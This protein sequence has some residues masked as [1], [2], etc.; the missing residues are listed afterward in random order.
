MSG[1]THVGFGCRVAICSSVR[2]DVNGSHS[3]GVD[4]R[5]G[6]NVRSASSHIESP[7][8]RS[9]LKLHAY[10]Q[11]MRARS[12][13]L[14]TVAILACSLVTMSQASAVPF[15]ASANALSGGV[16]SQETQTIPTARPIGDIRQLLLDVEANAKHTEAAQRDY[17]Y[18]VRTE[19]Q[20]LDGHEQV[21]KITVTE[22]ESLT[23]Q[24]VRVNRVTSRNGNALT[25]DELRKEDERIDKA[26][27]RRKEQRE[28]LQ[29][30]GTASDDQGNAMLPASR[31]L[32]LGTFSNPRRE[33][34]E[35]RST[36]LLDYAGDPHAK[37]N[38][39]FEGV[40]RNLIGTVWIDEADRMLVRARGEFRDN[41]KIG[42][43][44]LVNVHKGTHFQF[45]A[46]RQADAVWL[47]YDIDATG[48]A[49]FLVVDGFNGH[50]HVVTSDYRRFRA[51][52]TILESSHVIGPDDQPESKSGGQTTTPAD[53]PAAKPPGTELH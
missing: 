48:S 1:L 31:I 39:T 26:V 28:K 25:A 44:L 34:L 27:E 46:A 4:D 35:G 40:V 7:R 41:F 3:D 19:A 24:G 21:K 11:S 6:Y 2:S 14:R 45:R 52:A 38:N 51:N 37:T 36:I 42:G 17:T 33:L 15:T 5:D 12:L 10:S 16:S 49:R 8:S 30:K 43:G 29:A 22:A 23:L 32:E 13:R 53:A 50:V 18:H 20:E 47:P 9:R